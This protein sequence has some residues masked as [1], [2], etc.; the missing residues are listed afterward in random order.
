MLIVG[1][2]VHFSTSVL[3]DIS[4]VILTALDEQ[5]QELSLFNPKRT[6]HCTQHENVFKEDANRI[7]TGKSR[8]CA[9]EA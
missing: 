2:N 8:L 1:T 9:I 4:D 5:V 6:L 3:T 7:F